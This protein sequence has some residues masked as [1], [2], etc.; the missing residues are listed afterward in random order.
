[1]Q[2]AFT[3]DGAGPRRASLRLADDSS[4]GP[5][6]VVL[7]GTGDNPAP[8]A[9]TTTAATTTV[10]TVTTSTPTALRAPNRAFTIGGLKGTRL[11]VTV[12]SRGTVRVAGRL[13]RPSSATGGPGVVVVQLRPTA[14]ARTSLARSHR[15]ELRVRL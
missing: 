7:T 15:L 9:T 2:H 14:P 13:L 4:D 11:R 3:P 12:G 1:V 5:H 8:A 6:T 10:T